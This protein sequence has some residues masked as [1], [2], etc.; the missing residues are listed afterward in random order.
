MKTDT[1][2]YVYADDA[3]RWKGAAAI[4]TVAAVVL[5]AVFMALGIPT[6]VKL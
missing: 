4:V 3:T 5:L 6:P 1:V 2:R